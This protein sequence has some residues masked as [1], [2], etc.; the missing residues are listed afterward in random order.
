MRGMSES[1]LD[2]AQNEK[3]SVPAGHH[4]PHG[5]RVSGQQESHAT[6][7]KPG[8]KPILQTTT[9]QQPHSRHKSASQSD[10]IC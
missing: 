4:R 6:N 1:A 3:R 10:R 7:P 8:Q 5:Q 9:A 2:L